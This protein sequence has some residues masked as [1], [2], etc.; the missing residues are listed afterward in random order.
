MKTDR[1]GAVVPVRNRAVMAETGL[2]SPPLDLVLLARVTATL[3][4]AHEE[5]LL[6]IGAA[7]FERCIPSPD[8]ASREVLY[9]SA[10]LAASTRDILDLAQLRLHSRHLTKTCSMVLRL[11]LHLGPDFE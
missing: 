9:L 11:C 5:H 4:W 2:R 10:I 7:I 3:R 8:R 1:V 6:V